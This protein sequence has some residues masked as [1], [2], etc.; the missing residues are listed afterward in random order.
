MQPHEGVWVV[1]VGRD[2]G[3]FRQWH[4]ISEGSRGRWGT[5]TIML[6]NIGV[7]HYMGVPHQLIYPLVIVTKWCEWVGIK[8]SLI[9]QDFQSETFW[10]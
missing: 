10:Q 9:G 3:D 6:P 4:Y 5:P 7:P 2:E 1:G 8:D